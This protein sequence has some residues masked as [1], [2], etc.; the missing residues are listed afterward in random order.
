VSARS[1]KRSKEQSRRKEKI[2]ASG[3]RRRTVGE[4]SY[5]KRKRGCAETPTKKPKWQKAHRIL[6]TIF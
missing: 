1:G 6:N 4:E 5:L 2:Y 3:S